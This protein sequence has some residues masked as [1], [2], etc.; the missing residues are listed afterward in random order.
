[1]SRS[2]QCSVHASVHFFIDPMR[3]GHDPSS[4]HGNRFYLAICMPDHA[5]ETA[6]LKLGF[7]DRVGI[8]THYQVVN[9]AAKSGD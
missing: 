5:W 3:V 4:N 7:S 1:L 6:V 8:M 9:P 2:K